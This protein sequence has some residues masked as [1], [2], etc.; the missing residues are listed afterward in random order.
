M[1]STNTWKITAP[2]A[3]LGDLGFDTARAGWTID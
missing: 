2:V 1:T 3:A